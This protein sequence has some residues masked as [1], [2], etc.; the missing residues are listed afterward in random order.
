MKKA[1]EIL[2]KEIMRR[3]YTL[4]VLKNIFSFYFLRIIILF[5][6]GFSFLMRVSVLNVLNNLPGG[7]DILANYRYLLSAFINTDFSVQI[8]ISLIVT[9]SAWLAFG[10]I[11]KII[12]DFGINRSKL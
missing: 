2:K 12:P 1:E 9:I 3:V 4:W 7:G 5:F 11:L 8:Y 6:A 10:Y